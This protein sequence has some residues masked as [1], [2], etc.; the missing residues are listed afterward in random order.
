MYLDGKQSATL[1]CKI[2]KNKRLMLKMPPTPKGRVLVRVI[3][4][5]P[6]APSY[7][8]R[9][10][11]RPCLLPGPMTTPPI[12]RQMFGLLRS[13]KLRVGDMFPTVQHFNTSKL[14]YTSV[15]LLM[16][17]LFGSKSEIVGIK[18]ESLVS[19]FTDASLR[20]AW[21]ALVML[22]LVS[23][24]QGAENSRYESDSS[25]LPDVP[26]DPC[27]PPHTRAVR[28]RPAKKRRREGTHG[29]GSGEIELPT[30]V[31]PAVRLE[32]IM[33]VLVC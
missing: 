11:A 15:P 6:A 32:I 20:L 14:V 31:P 1:A 27:E 25:A 23:G 10:P 13:P 21:R 22:H 17:M 16:A 28:G 30:G 5:S 9:H 26:L 24:P 12:K 29:P 33:R 18:L 4:R 8:T 7:L 2:K 19:M 3:E